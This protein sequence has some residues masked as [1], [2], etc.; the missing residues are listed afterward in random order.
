[1]APLITQVQ[2][3]LMIQKNTLDSIYRHGDKKEN[4]NRP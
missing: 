1:M 2:G 3:I 4:L